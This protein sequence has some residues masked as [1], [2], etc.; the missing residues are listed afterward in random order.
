MSSESVTVTGGG[1]TVDYDANHDPDARPD[2]VDIPGLGQVV[3]KGINVAS[4]GTVTFVYTTQVPTAVGDNAFTVAFRAEGDTAFTDVKSV[5]LEGSRSERGFRDA[6]DSANSHCYHS[7]F[8]KQ[9]TD[10]YLYGCR[11]DHRSGVRCQNPQ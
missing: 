9:S 7:C 8:Y 4:G 1:G 11:R 10:L 6:C 3:T 2:G 5:T